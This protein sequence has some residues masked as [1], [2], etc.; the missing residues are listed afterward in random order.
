MSG[1]RCSSRDKTNPLN[2]NTTHTHGVHCATTPS[3]AT[4]DEKLVKANQ[5]EKTSSKVEQAPF[6]ARGKFPM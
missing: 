4:H 3:H 2:P 5:H 1:I 6:S